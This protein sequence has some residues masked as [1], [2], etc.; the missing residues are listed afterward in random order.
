M[1][2]FALKKTNTGIVMA[3]ALAA[4]ALSACQNTMYGAGKDIENA[5]ESMQKSSGGPHE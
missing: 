5:G 1:N 2:T 4:L 3:L